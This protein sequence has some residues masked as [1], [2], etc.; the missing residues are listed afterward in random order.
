MLMD[1][2]LEEAFARVGRCVW[3][4]DCFVEL[5]RPNG[6]AAHVL[7]TQHNRYCIKKGGS[8]KIREI[9]AQLSGGR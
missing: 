1:R 5:R 6:H 7:F 8:Q 4:V 3:Q 2:R 9:P